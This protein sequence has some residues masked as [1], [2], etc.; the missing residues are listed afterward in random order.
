MKRMRTLRRKLFAGFGLLGAMAL[1]FAACD[2][3][4]IPQPLPDEPKPT[5]AFTF[6]QHSDD[7]PFTYSF[8]NGATNFK[9]VRWEFGDDSS[10]LEVSPLHTFLYTG[11]FRVTLRAENG[12]GF[13]AQ[14]ET[15]ISIKPE[16]VFNL[17][18]TPAAGG[19]L[20]LSVASGAAIESINWY[21]GTGTGAEFI[22]SGDEINIEVASGQ[23]QEYTIR[24]ETPNGSQAEVSHLLTDLGIVR[25]VTADGNLSV[26][27]DNSGGMHAGEG[28]LKLTDNNIN[29]KFL[30]FDYSGDLWF[31]LEFYQPVVLGGYT[32]TSANDASQRDP[33]NWRLEATNDGIT[34]D[35]LDTRNDETFATRF[36]TRTF[37]FDNSQAYT[38][39][40]VYVTAVG[41][42]TLFQM[43]EW[44]VLSLPQ[45]D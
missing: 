20:D 12:Q 38:R 45:T 27:R 43:A 14:R 21:K 9:E 23:F 33:R 17:V 19:T 28:S 30:Q 42:G 35:V 4:E 13:W 6:E 18:A 37:I 2:S 24:V 44:R 31:E 15:V 40:R 22:A 39:Y 25:D 3:E 36:L 32:F 8:T 7:D 41:D 1:V 16:D 29:S 10:S 11:D 26:S 34:W 5:A